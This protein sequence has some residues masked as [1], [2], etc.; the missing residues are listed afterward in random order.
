[1]GLDPL[2][3]IPHI[4]LCVVSP[5]DDMFVPLGSNLGCPQ[6]RCMGLFRVWSSFL[7]LDGRPAVGVGAVVQV[8]LLWPGV[9]DVVLCM[10]CVGG[11]W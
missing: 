7:L 9:V 4:R 2:V 11:C 1:M 6:L 3:L 8:Y 10:L 5:A